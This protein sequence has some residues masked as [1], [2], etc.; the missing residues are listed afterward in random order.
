[1]TYIHVVNWVFFLE[2]E[3]APQIYTGSYID[4]HHLNDISYI[5]PAQKT[6]C[7]TFNNVVTTRRGFVSAGG[8]GHIDFK[9]SGKEG[10]LRNIPQN[11]T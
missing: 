6:N 7:I 8:H 4:K 5:N 11:Q 1:M 10:I 2:P 9:E 3:F